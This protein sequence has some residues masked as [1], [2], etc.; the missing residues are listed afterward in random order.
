MAGRGPRRKSQIQT[1]CAKAEAYLARA[2]AS[3]GTGIPGVVPVVYPIT[4]FELSYGLY[5][6]LLTGILNLPALQDVVQP[7]LAQLADALEP[8]QGLSFGDSFVPDVD[9]TSVA[10]ASLRAA[11]YKTQEQAVRRFFH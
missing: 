9:V 3:T 2:E 10:I 6:L 4:G 5:A 7:K 1:S 11:G 8:E